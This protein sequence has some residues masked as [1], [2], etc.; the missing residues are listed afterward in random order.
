MTGI[1]DTGFL[2]AFANRADAHHAWA[3]G[4]AATIEEPLLT[5]EA[6]IA[7]TIFHLQDAALVLQMIQTGLIRLDFDARAHLPELTA[8]ARK[9]ADRQPDFADL[10]PHPHER[11]APQAAYLD[12]GWRL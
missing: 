2:A 3:V 4:L 12:R 8:S 10:L 1:A 6:V 7:E 5:C 11:A 9:S